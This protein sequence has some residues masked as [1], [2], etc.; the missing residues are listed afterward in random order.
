MKLP[1][2]VDYTKRVDDMI[3]ALKLNKASNTKIGGPLFKGI[4]GGERK[5]TSIG[6]ELI[7]DP[8]LVFLDEPTTGLD[9]FTAT[10]VVEVLRS[11]A[12]SGRTVISTIHQPN[13][14][15]FRMFDHLMLMTCGK[16]IYMN[17][18][19]SA[20]KYFSTIG[21]PVPEQTNPADFF[22]NLMSV[23]AY[24]EPDVDDNQELKKSQS[25]LM[26]DYRNKIRDLSG[27]YDC[28]ELKCD[29]ED[30]HPD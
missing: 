27:K 25:T 24:K 4:S 1:P 21:Y 9:S 17:K 12:E 18:A 14:E 10:T 3:D 6:V 8:S 29:P 5:R 11:L 30:I 13:S 28:S 20:S 23:E 7:T 26:N 19:E 15:T 16:I 22:M 2:A